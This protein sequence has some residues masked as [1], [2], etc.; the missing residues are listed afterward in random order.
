[1]NEEIKSGKQICDNFFRHL[2]ELPN[3]DEKTANVLI[4]LHQKD[5]LTATNISNALLKIRQ[6]VFDAKDKDI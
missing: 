6:E 5:N 1:M 2:K 4:D 3:V